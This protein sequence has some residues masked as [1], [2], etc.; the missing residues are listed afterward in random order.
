MKYL[1]SFTAT[2]LLA[3]YAGAASPDYKAFRGT[4]GIVVTT[5]P[6]T[7]TVVIDGSGISGGSGP[8]TNPPPY[9]IPVVGTTF[10]INWSALGP[11]NDVIITN[12]A[13]GMLLNNTNI[14]PGK[15]IRARA[16]QGSQGFCTIVSNSPNL[17]F[18][19]VNTGFIQVTNGGFQDFFGFYGSGTNA[20]L[21]GQNW[22]A[23][24]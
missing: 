7:G 16:D 24:P 3:F 21:S 18:T 4:G 15:F 17:R 9:T 20:V 23:A 13:A 1:L 12:Y 8:S 5:N 11:T 19:S 2:L 14:I 22:G 6:P 10:I